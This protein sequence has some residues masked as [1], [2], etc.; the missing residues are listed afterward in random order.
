MWKTSSLVTIFFVLLLFS[1]TSA[2][3]F[4]FSL[5]QFSF[6]RLVPKTKDSSFFKYVVTSLKNGSVV[7]SVSVM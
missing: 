3:Q 5:I 1:K 4:E 6:N 2:N 7:L